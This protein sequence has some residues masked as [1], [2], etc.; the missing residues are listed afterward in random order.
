[1]KRH[2][3]D[4]NNGDD[5]DDES[6]PVAT[7]DMCYYCF[8]TL[9]NELLP[10]PNIP[11]SPQQLHHHQQFKQSNDH[12]G[13]KVERPPKKMDLSNSSTTDDDI[14]N[15]E[16]SSNNV[17]D[18][19]SYLDKMKATLKYHTSSYIP[20]SE[21]CP[22]FITWSKR[23]CHP[24]NNN[25]TDDDDEDE[26]MYNLR[27]CIGTLTPKSLSTALSEFAITSAFHDTR[28]DP[29]VLQ[30]VSQL[31]VCVSLLVKY[32]ECSHCLD[33]IVGVH[34][35]HIQFETPRCDNGSGRGGGGK[36]QQ[37]KNYYS[38]TFLPEVAYE[39]NWNQLDTIIALVRK[40]G[41]QPS[42]GGNSSSSI[43]NDEFMASIRCTRYQSSKCKLSY[44]DYITSRD[45]DCQLLLR[46]LRQSQENSSSSSRSGMKNDINV[47]MR[48][49]NETMGQRVVRPCVNL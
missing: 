5:D 43:R 11:S 44:L 1:M 33:W 2:D 25:G 19:Y 6:C 10:L 14:R 36:K 47:E 37:R 16:F 45:F 7:L 46:L 17:D 28:F 48:I 35:I 3:N 40:S 8:D 12:G 21:T 32:E 24:N 4:N 13:K 20:P 30:E 49:D 9:L 41:Y 31:K 22:L 38:A 26:T 23:S 34:G 29:V 42:S 39:Q 27:G 18:Y 15:L